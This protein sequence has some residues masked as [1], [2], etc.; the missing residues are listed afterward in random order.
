[1][2]LTTALYVRE[3][4]VEFAT[5]MARALCKRVGKPVYVGWSGEMS[6]VAGTV[7]EEVQGWREVVDV[8]VGSVGK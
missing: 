4:T 3:D 1:M 8:V 7:E 2:P 5:R 6:G